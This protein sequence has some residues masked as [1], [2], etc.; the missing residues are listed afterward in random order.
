MC[1]RWRCGRGEDRR[2]A[3]TGRSAPAPADP[4]RWRLSPRQ[5][6]ETPGRHRPELRRRVVM[7]A[8]GAKR[9]ATREHP[10]V[11]GRRSAH[12]L[13]VRLRLTRMSRPSSARRGTRGQPPVPQH[14]RRSSRIID[15]SSRSLRTVGVGPARPFSGIGG[16]S[17]TKG[18]AVA[19]DRAA[20]AVRGDRARP[21]SDR[22][23]AA[24]R[25]PP[26]AL[27]V[28]F[29][30]RPRRLRRGRRCRRRARPHGD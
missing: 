8:G 1:L 28:R 21:R 25:R 27:D 22:S 19:A 5:E 23:E 15:V 10:V 30:P 20:P 12:E 9:T 16:V 29:H 14:S 13:L 11:C 17:P 4:E 24:Q 3:A 6:S 7:L 2:G 26:V 18:E